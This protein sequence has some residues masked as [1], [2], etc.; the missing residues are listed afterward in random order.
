MQK[1]VSLLAIVLVACQVVAMGATYTDT[2]NNV[3]PDQSWMF[4]DEIG[5]TEFWLADTGLV[6][7]DQVSYTVCFGGTANLDSITFSPIVAFGILSNNVGSPIAYTNGSLTVHG[8]LN[9]DGGLAITTNDHGL[10]GFMGEADS[11][12]DPGYGYADGYLMMNSPTCHYVALYAIRDVGGPG[13]TSICLAIDEPYGQDP[14]MSSL[15]DDACDFTMQ[16][17]VITTGPEAG[18]VRISGLGIADHNNDGTD[19]ISEL[20][21]IVGSD[22][23]ATS[24]YTTADVPK[25][26]SGYVGFLGNVSMD[27]PTPL[28]LSVDDFAAWDSLPGDFDLD[29]DVDYDDYDILEPNLGNTTGQTVFQGDADMDGDVD[30]DDY[31]IWAANVPE[32]GTITL[33]GMAALVLLFVRRK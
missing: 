21:F 13:Q 32:P 9:A 26:F 30:N 17:E 12:G 33:L 15:M 18:N 25:I 23:P 3:A 27:F 14:N 2:F 19:E 4:Q 28:D 11:A 22:T 5:S 8:L 20:Q 1:L 7:P 31:N 16:I 24:T 10:F 29:G 6:T